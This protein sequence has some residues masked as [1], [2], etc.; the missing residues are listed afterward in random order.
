L[1]RNRLAGT[2]RQN[3]SAQRTAKAQ[4]LSR[5]ISESRER[6]RDSENEKLVKEA[7]ETDLQAQ[8]QFHYAEPV[9]PLCTK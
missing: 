2:S 8:K 1:G 9:L 3:I 6:E 5:R 4:G 7:P